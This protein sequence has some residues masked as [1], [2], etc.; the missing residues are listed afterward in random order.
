MFLQENAIPKN[1]F[2]GTSELK[3]RFTAMNSGATAN[4]ETDRRFLKTV[5]DYRTSRLS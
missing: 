3:L 2:A 4:R 5:A 1:R